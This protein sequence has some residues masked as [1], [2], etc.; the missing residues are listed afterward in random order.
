[1]PDPFRLPRLKTL[2]RIVDAMGRPSLAFLKFFNTDFAG[3]I[4]RQEGVQ[5][6]VD[7]ALQAVVDALA[8]TVAALEV[9]VERLTGQTIGTSFADGLTLDA[10]ADGATAK[11]TISAHTRT[12]TDDSSP[13][14]AGEV[15]GLAYGATY[16][17]YYDDADREGGAV[18]Y[19][20]TDD[21]TEAVTSASHPHRHLVGVV[22]TPA[23]DADP[24]TSGGGTRPPGF[25]P[26]DLYQQP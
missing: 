11:A 12:Y 22:T 18:T 8:A 14:S 2:D 4:E 10:A 6:N 9:Q 7:A 20:A 17:I 25:P 21:P 13:V 5:A 19:E 16:S 15:T 24:P 3:A 23:T 26:G 1:M